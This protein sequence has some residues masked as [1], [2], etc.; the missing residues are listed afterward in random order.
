[1]GIIPVHNSIVNYGMKKNVNFNP[2]KGVN[3]DFMLVKD[4]SIK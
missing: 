4:M 3:F 1:V 2:T